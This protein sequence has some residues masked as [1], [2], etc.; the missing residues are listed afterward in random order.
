MTDSLKWVANCEHCHGSAE[1]DSREEGVTWGRNHIAE[2]HAE[3]DEW[4]FR[5]RGYRLARPFPRQVRPKAA[6]VK[7]AKVDEMAELEQ[8]AAQRLR[9][10]LQAARS[11]S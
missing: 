7:R 10:R 3:A 4:S 1:V 11:A 6:T 5:V 9:E 2:V 8:E